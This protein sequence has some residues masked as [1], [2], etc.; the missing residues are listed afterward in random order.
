M[1]GNPW[2]DPEIYQYELWT[3]QIKITGQK[4]PEEMPHKGNSNNHE[5]ATQALSPLSLW[6]C[7]CAYPHIPYSF[8]LNTWLVSL[9]SIFVAI[10]FCKAKGPGPLLLTTGLAARIRCSH[11]HDPAQAPL[12]VVAGWGYRRPQM[13]INRQKLNSFSA[14]MEV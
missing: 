2:E 7:L 11:C 13:L 8:S 1:R 9:L 12:Q 6:V 5:G 3:R 10:L 14:E 4:K